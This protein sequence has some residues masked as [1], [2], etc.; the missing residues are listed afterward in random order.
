[1]HFRIHGSRPRVPSHIPSP[2]LP[3]PSSPIVS[4]THLE[5][6]NEESAET[7]WAGT[8]TV[9]RHIGPVDA[10][11]ELEETEG[12]VQGGLTAQGENT[13]L[14]LS[15]KWKAV[16]RQAWKAAGDRVSGRTAAASASK[17]R[18][19]ASG[20]RAVMLMRAVTVRQPLTDCTW[21]PLA[22]TSA[23]TCSP[24]PPASRPCPALTRGGTGDPRESSRAGM[25]GFAGGS[26]P[27]T[28][29]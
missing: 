9:L 17:A 4:H 16:S 22:F 26:S 3:R 14:C 25:A 7:H 11:R 21:P 23:S 19:A 2:P 28:P 20:C 6:L 5:R 13:L 24:L 10:L 18:G 15:A 12:C 1:M 29:T 8:R 27:A